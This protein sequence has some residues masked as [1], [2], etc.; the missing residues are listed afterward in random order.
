M[1]LFGKRRKKS[2]R[3]LASKSG[4]G[5]FVRELDGGRGIAARRRVLAHVA[6]TGAGQKSYL[7]RH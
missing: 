5:F 3:R 4:K 1:G 6:D 7:G 2:R